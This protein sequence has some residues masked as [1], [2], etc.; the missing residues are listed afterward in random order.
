MGRRGGGCAGGEDVGGGEAEAEGFGV[1]A[2]VFED[3]VGEG[4]GAGGL[5]GGG[6]FCGVDPEGEELGGEVAGAGGGEVEVGGAKGGGEGRAGEV[7]EALGGVG[8]GVED[9]G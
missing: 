6:E 7:E 2:D 5:E 1:A 8:V 3:G 9:E 4:E